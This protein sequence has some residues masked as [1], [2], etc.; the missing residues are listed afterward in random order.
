MNFVPEMINGEL[1][2]RCDGVNPD[3]NNMYA[4]PHTQWDTTYII[5][6]GMNTGHVKPLVINAYGCEG[7]VIDEVQYLGTPT[8]SEYSHTT[9]IGVNIKHGC[10]TGSGNLALNEEHCLEN[11]FETSMDTTLEVNWGFSVTH[12]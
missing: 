8:S 12:G 10:G 1:F 7:A 11:S 4:S 9:I 6:R 2:L 3:Y 5:C